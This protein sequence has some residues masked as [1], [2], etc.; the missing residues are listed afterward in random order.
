MWAP[1]AS[2]LALGGMEHDHGIDLRT[3]IIYL[4]DKVKT[5]QLRTI[6]NKVVI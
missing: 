6:F 3:S 2:V 1:L 4:L 5:N